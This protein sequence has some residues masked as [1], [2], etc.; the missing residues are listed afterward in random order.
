MDILQ[1]IRDMITRGEI[2]LQVDV[3]RAEQLLGY[4]HTTIYEMMNT[5]QL[6]WTRQGAARRIPIWEIVAW[7]D[8]NTERY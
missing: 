3:K 4:S 6:G 5:G 7:I 1:L 2:P 8:K